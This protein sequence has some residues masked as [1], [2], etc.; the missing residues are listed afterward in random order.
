MRRLRKVLFSLSTGHIIFVSY[1]VSLH[2]LLVDYG[3]SIQCSCFS[4]FIF[5]IISKRH[6]LVLV[7]FCS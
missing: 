4:F 2:F 6:K 1:L 5:Y 3:V 7:T